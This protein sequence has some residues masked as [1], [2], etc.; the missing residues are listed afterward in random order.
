MNTTIKVFDVIGK[1]AIS[2]QSGDKIYLLLKKN[3]K[4]DHKVT[5]DFSGVSLFASP[6]FNTAIG[7]L[8]KDM[9]IEELQKQLDFI[10]LDE[11]GN[12]LL[13]LVIFNA[14]NYYR[15]S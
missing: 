9:E 5:L 11:V 7:Y 1:N 3:M 15:K 12:E 10:N 13:N 14:I 8:L 4:A 2:M 6:F